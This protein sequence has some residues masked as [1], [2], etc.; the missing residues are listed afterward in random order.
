MLP[1]KAQDGP[2][3]QGYLAQSAGGLYLAAIALLVVLVA[4]L[5]LDGAA[6]RNRQPAAQ[7]AVR[8]APVPADPAERTEI[9][10]QLGDLGRELAEAGAERDRLLR[11]IEELLALHA[12]LEAGGDADAKGG[13]PARLA[14][15][16]R[17]LAAVARALE[18]A[19][20]RMS[21]RQME[22]AGLG[23]RL[24]RALVARAEELRKS[25]SDFLA[26]LQSVLGERAGFRMEGDRFTLPAEILFAPG[27]DRLSPKG[28]EEVRRLAATINAVRG[29]FPPELG[30]VLRV[31]GHT[32]RQPIA[33]ARFP[34]N[35]ELS[36]LRAV[37][38]V[39]VL[40]EEGIPPEH[41]AAAGFGEHQSLSGG[42]DGPASAQDRRIEFRIDTP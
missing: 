33:N 41:L 6:R 11:R 36:A 39:K 3:I 20:Q 28:T 1:P 12:E 8:T 18:A 25:R 40:A 17:E 2:Q 7:P 5:V 10:R 13:L 42:R 32:D 15:I 31:G 37:T 23:G 27:S 19:E 4:V 24:N 34:S 9:L 14:E 16:E 35:W 26:R 29:E 22:V 21:L 30:W 38:V